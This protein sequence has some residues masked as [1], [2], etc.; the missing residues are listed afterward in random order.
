M[1]NRPYAVGL[2]IGG[3]FTDFVLLDE[4]GGVSVHKVL[5]TPAD[6]AL[7]ALEGLAQLLSRAA[8]ALDQV[9]LLV[10]STTL[11]TNALI[12]QRGARTGLL[13]TSGFRDVLEMRDE[14]RYDI[15]DLFLTWPE[16]LV[17]RDRRLGVTERIT[18]DGVVLTALD[19]GEVVAAADRLVSDGVEAIAVSFLH[20]YQNPT[21]EEAVAALLRE[22][23]PG[24]PVTLSSRV[25]PVMREYERTST[26][27][28]DAFVR[29]LADAYL[30]RMEAGLAALGFRGRFYLMLSGGGSASVSSAREHVIRL[31]ESGPAAGA[32]AAG[33]Y[34]QLTDNDP[35]L[36]FDMGGTTAKT[37]VLEG[38]RPELVNVLEVG[39]TQR[40]KRGSG[41]PLV[42]PSVELLEIGAGGGSIARIDE[43]GFLKVGP[44]S[45]GAAPGPACYGLGGSQPTVTDAN[46]LL[47]YLDPNY[48]LGGRM[49]LDVEAARSALGR[50]ADAAGMSPTEAAWG[51]HQVVNENMAQAAMM[52][53][54][55]RNWDPRRMT[56][57]AFG[58]AGPAHAGAIA[59]RL[60]ARRILFPLGAGATSALGC[61]AAPLSFQFTRSLPAVLRETDWAGVNALFADLEARGRAALAEAGVAPEQVT[62]RREADL[63][64]YGQ[65]HEVMIDV[66]AGPLGP[67]SIAPLTEAFGRVYRRLYSRFNPEALLEVV[68]WKLTALGPPRPVELRQPG[69][70]RA[71]LAAASKGRRPVYLQRAGGFVDCP[72][73]DRYLLTPGSRLSGPAILEERETTI[74]LPPAASALVDEFWDLIVELAPSENGAARA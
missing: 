63:R 14:H 11:V 34:G 70:G 43:L 15:Y 59:H 42:I 44:D 28:A 27:V 73:Y 8:V 55:E 50:L 58:G 49:A 13:T 35:I 21:H 40:F 31:V 62:M 17:P 7:A 10:H 68:N 3:T 64:I 24:I 22:R 53:L 66:P 51:V 19:T 2:D 6:P 46:L 67:D 71:G 20:A 32:L 29:P 39:R 18:R 60:G 9:D 1:T 41:L 36:S 38:G 74:V 12:E 52:H 5:T 4:R 65:I 47:G 57:V 26:A 61:L 72:V 33:L 69:S 37:C 23:H 16:P 30:S 25:A 56:L 45:A 48:F 54:V